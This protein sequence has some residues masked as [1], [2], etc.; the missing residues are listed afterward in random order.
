MIK[1]DLQIFG[2]RGS[3]SGLPISRP[4]G[5]GGGPTGGGLDAAPGMMA[6]AEEALG[7][8]GRPMGIVNAVKNANPNYNLGTEYQENCQRCVI[9]T[10]ARLRGYNVQALP[11]YDNDTMPSGTNYLNNFVGAKPM[12]VKH[13]TPNA[14]RNDIEGK[15]ADM[16]NGARATMSFQWSGGQSGHV[17]NVVQRGG[18]TRYYD[19]Q[20]GTEVSASHLYNAISNSKSITLTRV[21]NL[22]FSNSVNAALRPTI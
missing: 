2:G 13:T 15:M 17:I 21:D 7:N 3:S 8:Q 9:A 4:S 18:K 12:T 6:T 1:V 10:E 5:G 20:N 11:T 22:Q 16:G 19:G 14:N